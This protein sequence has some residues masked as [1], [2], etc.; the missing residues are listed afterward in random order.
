MVADLVD[1]EEHRARDM[2]IGVLGGRVARRA[3][4]EPGRID[5][6]QIVAVQTRR[7]PVGGNQGI[8]DVYS[9]GGV[10]RPRAA[11]NSGLKILL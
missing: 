6:H 8:H 9:Q 11:R 2:P 4:H 10:G 7:E 1:I 3:G 5:D